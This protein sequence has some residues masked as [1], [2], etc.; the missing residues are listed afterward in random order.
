MLVMTVVCVVW[1]VARRLL[2]DGQLLVAAS[3][4]SR[5]PHV[6]VVGKNEVWPAGEDV[7]GADRGPARVGVL[8]VAVPEPT[9]H[10]AR[11]CLLDY[12]LDRLLLLLLAPVT[13]AT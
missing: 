12:H 5:T 10:L 6:G 8:L 13:P 4:S 11:P 3:G 2:R 7:L 9:E 1:S